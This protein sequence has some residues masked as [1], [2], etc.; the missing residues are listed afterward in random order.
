[1]DDNIKYGFFDR[2]SYFRFTVEQ[3]EQQK[4]DLAFYII[5]ELADDNLE[6]IQVS[7]VDVKTLTGYDISIENAIKMRKLATDRKNKIFSKTG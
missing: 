6:S 4:K 7:I 3:L 2:A 5:T 1:M